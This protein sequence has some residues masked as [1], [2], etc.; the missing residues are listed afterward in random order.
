MKRLFLVLLM[1]S[2]CA[3]GEIRSYS[4]IVH[5]PGPFGDRKTFWS[6]NAES[7]RDAENKLENFFPNATSAD[8]E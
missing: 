1:L 3:S 7:P 2:G 8:C 6:L 4:C 5:Q